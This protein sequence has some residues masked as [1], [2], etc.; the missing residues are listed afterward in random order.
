MG[1]GAMLR[2]CKG[3]PGSGLC[4]RVAFRRSPVALEGRFFGVLA[5]QNFP[6]RPAWGTLMVR[7]DWDGY[8]LYACH[9]GLQMCT[10]SKGRLRVRRNNVP[11]EEVPLRG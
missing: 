6:V 3:V 9:L 4:G 8:T 7:V 5:N 10:V 11:L 1:N 2:H